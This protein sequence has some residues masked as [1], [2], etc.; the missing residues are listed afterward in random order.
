MK[1][2][3]VDYYTGKHRQYVKCSP[4][5]PQAASLQV[6]GESAANVKAKLLK[7]LVEEASQVLLNA[8]AIS[9]I[10]FKCLLLG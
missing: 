10:L 6:G 5:T 4:P 2:K 9:S 8:H 1:V 3:W 7:D